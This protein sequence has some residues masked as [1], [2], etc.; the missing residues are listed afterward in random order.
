MTNTNRAKNLQITMKFLMDSLD[1]RN[2]GSR[3]YFSRIYNPFSGWSHMYPET[4]GY[5]IPTFIKYGKKFNKRMYINKAIRMADW[6]LSVQ[7]DDG[8]FPGGL[9]K[10][11]IANKSIFNSAQIIIGLANI[12]NETKEEKYLES[13][14]KS[15]NWIVENQNI[16]GSWSR[17]NYKQDY[18]PSYYTR[19]AWPLLMVWKLTENERLKGAAIK[20]LNLIDN[21]KSKNGFIEHSGFE[22]NTYAFTH[23]IA[24][25][26]R[27]FIESGEILQINKYVETAINWANTIMEEFEINGK[28]PGSYF[29]NSKKVYSFECLTGYSQLAIIWLR[30]FEKTEDQRYINSA[31]KA[32]DRVSKF[33]PKRT[34]L[35]KKGGVPGSHPFWGRY[36]IFRQPNWATKFFIDAILLESEILS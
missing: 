27:G 25:V 20:S 14:I 30:I 11:S 23:T 17:Y 1:K 36:M 7:Y 9:Y 19:V 6:L 21:R 16:D 31:I 32:I 33:I 5:I 10:K 28:L 3:A 13:S 15:A 12:Y 2:G 35:L 34:L 8:S 4:T 24:Y 29:D 26:I 22:E 18:S